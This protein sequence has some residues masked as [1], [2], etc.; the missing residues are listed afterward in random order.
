MFDISKQEFDI[1]EKFDGPFWLKFRNIATAYF[2]ML[3]NCIW[4]FSFLLFFSS[5]FISMIGL[6]QLDLCVE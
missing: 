5:L 3:I 2:Y 6:L 1:L 4:L